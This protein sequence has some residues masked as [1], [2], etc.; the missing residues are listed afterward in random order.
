MVRYKKRY[1]VVQLDRE[2]DLISKLDN[3]KSKQPSTD[4]I[5][6]SLEST[7]NKKKRK[8][9]LLYKSS[10]FKRALIDPQP[11]YISDNMLV[12]TLKDLVGQIHGDFGRASVA[13]GLRTIYSNAETRLCLIQVRHGPHKLLASSL[14][15]L[16]RI[17]NEKIVPR[18]IYTGATIR[19]CYKKMLEYQK[20]QLNVAMRELGRNS[21]SEEQSSKKDINP[22]PAN[23]KSES[24]EEYTKNTIL[25]ELEK[26]LMNIRSMES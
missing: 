5:E 15:F 11:L 16:T 1:F 20:E 17:K 12:N 25:E 8:K 3:I 23:R 13:T 4:N 24:I 26:K 18:L 7:S 6:I 14:P 21:L 19:N 2:S 9:Q 10:G 22:R